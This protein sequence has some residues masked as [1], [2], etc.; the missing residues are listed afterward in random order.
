MAYCTPAYYL[1]GVRTAHPL[2][3]NGLRLDRSTDTERTDNPRWVE[4]ADLTPQKTKGRS[5]FGIRPLV[6]LLVR[7]ILRVFLAK[8]P[9]GVILRPHPAQRWMLARRPTSTE[10]PQAVQPWPYHGHRTHASPQT[11]QLLQL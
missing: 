5:L 3:L 11:D 10:L 2:H 6:P 8:R 4:L 9:H 1:S 7:P